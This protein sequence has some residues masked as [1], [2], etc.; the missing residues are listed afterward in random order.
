MAQRVFYI[1]SI[2][3]DSLNVGSTAREVSLARVVLVPRRPR[4]RNSE[5]RAETDTEAIEK[6]VTDAVLCDG[7]GRVRRNWR[8]AVG[9]APRLA[10]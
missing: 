3:Q 9:E 10:A 5:G 8:L 4:H 1:D 7:A 2:V 6:V